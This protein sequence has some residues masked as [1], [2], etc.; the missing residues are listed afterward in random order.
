MEASNIGYYVDRRVAHVVLNRPEKRNALN[1]TMVNELIHGIAEANAD[2]HVR[3]IL[4]EA[5]GSAFCAGADLD[6]I[7][8]MRDE[9]FEANLEDSN[10]LSMLFEH[11]YTS[12]KLVIAQVEG[13]AIA[14]GCGLATVADLTYATPRAIFGYSEL[15]IGFVPAI[16]SPFLVRKIG[17]GRARELLLTCRNISAT[18]ALEWGMIHGIF[19]AEDIK[20]A[21]D[22]LACDWCERVSAESV[23]LTKKW[24]SDQ[25]NL[26]LHEAMQLASEVNAR[27]RGTTD[28][29]KGIDAFLSGTRMKW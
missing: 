16:V 25:W 12:E 4:I 27:A 29:R 19:E 23:L 6:Y 21:V 14:G 10:R 13:P 1:P 24:L 28:C 22:R 7:R 2:A 15:A 17:A 20:Q 3:V 8:Q 26:N 18:Q 11:I 5:A 9:S